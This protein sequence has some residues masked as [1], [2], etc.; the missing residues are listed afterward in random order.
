MSIDKV[1]LTVQQ[2][3]TTNNIPKVTDFKQWV[4]A[5][6][7]N[8]NTTAAE[9]T[10]RLVDEGE[11]AQLNHQYRNKNSA[12]NVLSLQYP[13]PE[14]APMAVLGDLVLCVPVISSEAKKQQK[15][16]TTHFAHL[17]V[18]GTLHLLGY[19]HQNLDDAEAME[20]LEIQILAKLGFSN[21]YD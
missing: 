21:P 13:V 9:I 12:T 14:S 4:Y 8:E 17:T 20:S 5:A 18:H 15:S 7:Q 1:E 11:G 10:I 2:C 3:S 19:D 16:L 6:L